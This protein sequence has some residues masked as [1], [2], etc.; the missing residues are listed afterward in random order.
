MNPRSRSTLAALALLAALVQ[1]ASAQDH[2]WRHGPGP[3]PGGRPE[4]LLLDPRYHHDHYYP[5]YGY[6]VPVLPTGAVSVAYRGAPWY[7]HGGVWFRGGGGRFVVS[8][9]PVGIVVPVLPPAFVTLGFGGL[10]YYYANGVYYSAV[11]GGY[12]VVA[13]PPGA[14]SAPPVAAPAPAVPAPPAAP[15]EP[16]VYPRNGQNAAQTEAD[17]RE[18]NRWATTQPSAVADASVFQR[19]VAACMDAHGYTLR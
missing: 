18:C 15:V 10:P 5:P 2:G 3:G 6:A 4:P 7:F 14:E 12:E 17:L 8:V 9:P 1:P 11:P 13:P 19:A 16:V